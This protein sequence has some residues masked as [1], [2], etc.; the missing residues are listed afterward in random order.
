MPQFKDVNGREWLVTLDGPTIRQVRKEVGIDLAATD[1]SASE[2]LYNDPVV[3]V[4]ALWVVCRAQASKAGVTSEQFGCALVGDPID[5]ATKALI[6]GIND[7]FPS[8]RREAMKALT[9][10]M[11]ETR[12]GGMEDA[13][14][15]L[16]DPELAQQIRGAMK[17]K[18]QTEI[19]KL[20]SE[21]TQS[22]SATKP[23]APS[24]SAPAG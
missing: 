17:V 7:F 3:L 8:R 21:L 12:E 14:A 13:L 9:A 15:T 10:R 5:D 6:D 18:A 2:R 4:D 20:L 1:G 24:G 23:P 19:Q 11:T 16:L 22:S